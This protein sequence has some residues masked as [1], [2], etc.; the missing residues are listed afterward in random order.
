MKNDNIPKAIR[1]LV[2]SAFLNVC[3]QTLPNA[4]TV[5]RDVIVNKPSLPQNNAILRQ[6]GTASPITTKSS[7]ATPISVKSITIT[8]A[9]AFS[10]EVLQALVAH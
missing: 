4:G 1:I 9:S 5:S 10:P 7:D 6:T 8:G 2:C 3:A